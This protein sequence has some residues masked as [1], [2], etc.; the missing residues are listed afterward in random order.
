[1]AENAFVRL[2]CKA[3]LAVYKVTKYGTGFFHSTL[4]ACV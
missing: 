1:M 3:Q 4:F 2:V